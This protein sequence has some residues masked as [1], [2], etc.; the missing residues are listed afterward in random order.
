MMVDFSGVTSNVGWWIS[1]LVRT[2][3]FVN[4][5]VS[6]PE[7]S[8]CQVGFTTL[9]WEQDALG[10]VLLLFSKNVSIDEV[11]YLWQSF[12]SLRFHVLFLSK[13]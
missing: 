10:P 11:F 2:R 9:L 6:D 3:V 5:T 4:K 8:V 12:Y 1:Q 7:A 13:E